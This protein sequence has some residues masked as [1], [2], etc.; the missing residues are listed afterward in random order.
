MI[1][2]FPT[3]INGLAEQSL[4]SKC[5]WPRQAVGP[6]SIWPRLCPIARSA[7]RSGARR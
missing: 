5:S 4:F 2:G 7:T 1:G 6:T 3:N